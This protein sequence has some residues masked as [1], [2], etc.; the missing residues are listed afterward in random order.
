MKTLESEAVGIVGMLWEYVLRSDNGTR[1]FLNL[2]IGDVSYF[3][4]RFSLQDISPPL[5]T[6]DVKIECPATT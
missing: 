6:P 3:I 4:H 1:L 2:P 5:T